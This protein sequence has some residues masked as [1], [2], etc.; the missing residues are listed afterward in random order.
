MDTS[1]TYIKMC[2]KAEEIQRL[3]VFEVKHG[4]SLLLE[5]GDFI[6]E[7]SEA[8]VIS[9]DSRS[10]HQYDQY[11]PKY[12]VSLAGFREGDGYETDTLVWLPTQAQLQ[13]MLDKHLWRLNGDFFD[14]LFDSVEDGWHISENNTDFLHSMEQFWL[15][16]VMFEL[17]QKVWNGEKW[18]IR[19]KED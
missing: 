1:E 8:I 19:R 15:G 12:S 5:D 16:F 14:W 10:I 3:K 9:D 13:A 2:E 18:G 6:W 11:R 17:H 4:S 7:G